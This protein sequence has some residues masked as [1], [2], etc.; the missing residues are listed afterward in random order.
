M[1]PHVHSANVCTKVI[2]ANATIRTILINKTNPHNTILRI[3]NTTISLILLYF[4]F[5]YHYHYYYCYEH[6]A[7]VEVV[8]GGAYANIESN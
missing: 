7:V 5:L 4:F 1:V 8:T 6:V 3:T 2:V